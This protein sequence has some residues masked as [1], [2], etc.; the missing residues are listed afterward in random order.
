MLNAE[1]FPNT[2]LEVTAGSGDNGAD[3]V[4]TVKR[5]FLMN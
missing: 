4:M 3:I 2:T 5:P 1:N